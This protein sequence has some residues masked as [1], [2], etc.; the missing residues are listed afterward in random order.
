VLRTDAIRNRQI[1]GTYG[2][3]VVAVRGTTLDEIAR[4]S[5]LVRLQQ[6]TLI[7]AG[8]LRAAGLGL[9]PTGRDP[10]HFDVAF[11]DVE[12]GVARLCGCEH[13]VYVSPYHEP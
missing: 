7:T 3:S 4:Q 6:L 8:V 5:P 9:E 12:E 1:F 2:I 11:D 13:R 10:H